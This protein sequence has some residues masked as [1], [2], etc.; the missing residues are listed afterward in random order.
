MPEAQTE[1]RFL[2]PQS[3]CGALVVGSGC[4]GLNAADW[5]AELGVENAALLTED[6]N[7]GTSRNAGSDKQTYYKLSLASSQ[8]DSVAEMAATLAGGIGV[9]GDT[10]L[11]EAA[12][13]AQCFIKLANL[14]VPFPTNRYGEYVGYRTDHDHWRR[15]T[16]AGPLTSRY[17]TDRLE[18]AVR[19]KGVAIFDKTMAVRLLCEAGRAYGL[20]AL[21]LDRLD[22]PSLGFRI[23]LADNIIAAVGGPASVYAASVYPESQSG[24][25]GML[26]EAGAPAANL[27]EWQYGLASLRPR[28]NVSGSY[29]QVLPRYIAISPDGNEREFLPEYFQSPW[30]ALHMAF[31][32]GYQWPFDMRE[33]AASSMV[34]IAVHHETQVMG[35][36]VFMDFTRN[37]SCLDE[38]GFGPLPLEAVDYLEKSRALF[39]RPID[40]LMA[41]NEPA[42]EF[43]RSHGVE[44]GREPLE[45][46]VCA[47]HCNGGI[48]VDIDWQSALKNLYVAGEAAGTFGVYRPGGSALNATQV[49]S[50]RAAAHIRRVGA[51]GEVFDASQAEAFVQ[52][53]RERLHAGGPPLELARVAAECRRDMTRSAAHI[54]D[55][56][57]FAALSRKLAQALERLEQG[58]VGSAG[59]LPAYLK[60]RDQLITQMAVVNA[61]QTA[62]KE[63]GSR[64]AGLTLDANGQAPRE[65]LE[66]YAY[67]QEKEA[68]RNRI[69]ETI[70]RDGVF[71]SELKA[72]RPVPE[73]DDWF[74]NVWRRHRND[75]LND[76]KGDGNARI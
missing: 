72:A 17:M 62:A 5:L 39:G 50:M 29:Q 13:S 4:A 26:L 73:A 20:L 38:S 47:Q 37:P 14:G 42:A 21:E 61:Q 59:E 23:F 16:S 41:M 48:A 65:G 66:M 8:A 74:E 24:M 6:M 70:Y 58:R 27:Q 63:F 49:G 3:R 31:R 1:N 40:R 19:E 55:P 34:D 52:H 45:V 15:A 53:C 57:A 36:R 51:G 43:Y 76:G 67:A 28:W 2:I 33:I 35:N 32:K 69:V 46:A 25:T 44:L 64:G 18:R 68:A 12:C 75:N 11:V 22:T 56:S 71:H 10:A 9:N 30:E 7:S 60:L 54:R